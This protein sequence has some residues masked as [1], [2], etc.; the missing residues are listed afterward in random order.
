VVIPPNGEIGCP[1]VVSDAVEACSTDAVSDVGEVACSEV[2]SEAVEVACSEVLS[3]A[4]E[5]CTCEVACGG[6]EV[7]CT[8]IVWDGL[9]VDCRD[10]VS[11]DV[12]VKSLGCCG[13]MFMVVEVGLGDR[14]VLVAEDVKPARAHCVIVASGCVKPSPDGILLFVSGVV[15]SSAVVSVVFTTKKCAHNPVSGRKK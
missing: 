7:S 13:T 3:D 1:A 9:E 8:D 4:V 5:V 10:G 14:V 6:S 15:V 11:D 2:L 12:A